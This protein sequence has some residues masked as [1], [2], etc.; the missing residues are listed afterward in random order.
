MDCFASLAMTTVKSED[1][2]LRESHVRSSHHSASL[3]P[4]AVLGKNPAHLRPEEYRLDLGPDFP[5]H[6]APRSDAADRRLSPHTGDAGRRR[7][8]LRHPMHHARVGT[9]L[10]DAV[11]AA[12]GF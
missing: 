1:V 9:S 6:A 4:V 12:E 3:R 2:E 8:L 11:A 7:H 10:S 5:D